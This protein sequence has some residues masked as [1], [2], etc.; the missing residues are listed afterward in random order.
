LYNGFRRGAVDKRSALTVSYGTPYC[1]PNPEVVFQINLTFLLDCLG[2]PAEGSE[3]T[4]HISANSGGGVLPPIDNTYYY[5]PPA[6]ASRLAG[7]HN[8]S[9]LPPSPLSNAASTSAIWS[10]ARLTSLQQASATAAVPG[11]EMAAFSPIDSGQQPPLL[12]GN[13]IDLQ[14]K[15]GRG[16]IM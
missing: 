9:Q 7:G 2:I 12:N 16:N 14:L 15:V 13:A 11:A 10:L 6:S 4:G 1:I 3:R 5:T 8:P